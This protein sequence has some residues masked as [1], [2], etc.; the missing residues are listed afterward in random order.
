MINVPII[1]TQNLRMRAPSAAD[2]DIDLEFFNSDRCLAFDEKRDADRTFDTLCFHMG[3]WAFRGFG[4]W[5]VE[6]KDD[7]TYYGRVG[8]VQMPSWDLP[9]LGWVLTKPMAEGK[10]IAFEAAVAVRDYAFSTLDMPK[11]QSTIRVGNERSIKLAKRLCATYDRTEEFPKH[12]Q[13]E[14]YIHQRSA[15]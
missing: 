2:F 13:C 4:L 14:V 10:G 15:A 7:H 12:G 1:E 11:L 5:A 6:H 9:E 3:H 8:L